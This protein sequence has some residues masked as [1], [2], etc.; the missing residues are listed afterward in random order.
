MSQ[1]IYYD[2]DG[3]IGGPVTMIQLQLMASSGMLLPHHRV[4][5][6]DSDQWYAARQVKG[7]F[8]SATE[9]APVASPV[10]P[11][12]G[13]EF[14]FG[15]WQES[16]EKVEESGLNSAFDFFGV[17]QDP[18]PPAAPSPAVQPL[19]TAPVE[20]P[21]PPQEPIDLP[22]KAVLPMPEVAAAPQPAPPPVQPPVP[23]P[24]PKPKAPDA[25]AAIE[26]G[27]QAIELIGVDSARLL[28]G[29]TVLTLR[30]GW[31]QAVS[32]FA[33]GTQRTVYLSLRSL[34]AATLEQRHATRRAKGG[35]YSVLSFSA[36]TTTV[37]LAIPSNDKPHR[38]FLD[39]VLA[40]SGAGK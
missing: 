16:G 14:P 32:K 19:V 39:K 3:R 38:A 37:A 11:P 29:K 4:R 33:D 18:S 1:R 20:V 15:T 12:S 27:G 23:E 17:H 5:K 30:R 21:P 26:I 22:P 24:K 13:E 40:L 9:A 28:D 2:I 10:T 31:L 35:P 34:D 6:D 25:T 8:N 7:L 36:G